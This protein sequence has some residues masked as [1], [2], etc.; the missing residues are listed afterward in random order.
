MSTDCN[1][2]CDYCYYSACHGGPRVAGNRIDFALLD[3]TIR[4]FMAASK[5][6]VGFAWQGGEPLLAGLPFFETVV[7]L[8]A[9]HAPPNTAIGNAIQTNGTLL[10]DAW[11]RFFR[12][13]SF[14]VGVSIDGPKDIHDRR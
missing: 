13:Y 3:R 9:Q 2:A 14:L 12:Q 11:A 8:Q 5:G 1:I 6:T 7:S 4:E 10:S